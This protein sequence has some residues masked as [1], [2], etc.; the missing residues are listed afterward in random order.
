MKARN[1]LCKLERLSGSDRRNTMEGLADPELNYYLVK[2]ADETIARIRKKGLAVPEW[3]ED[4]AEASRLNPM[5]PFSQ[6]R[7]E[8]VI[9]SLLKSKAKHGE[10]EEFSA[11]YWELLEALFGPGPMTQL[12]TREIIYPNAPGN[13]YLRE[14]Q[15][16]RGKEE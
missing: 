6:A 12:P 13:A 10:V 4:F 9:R 2:R 5:T 16:K 1:R 7:Y 11:K 3:L 14:R 15:A 8:A